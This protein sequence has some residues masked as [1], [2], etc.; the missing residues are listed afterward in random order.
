MFFVCNLRSVSQAKYRAQSSGICNDNSLPCS[1]TGLTIHL[2]FAEW[3]G[4]RH[5]LD[6][7]DWRNDT[8]SVHRAKRG[9]IQHYPLDRAKDTCPL[10]PNAFALSSSN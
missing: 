2:R 9:G 3:R 8:F 6:D 7:F 4:A 5:R 10:L 1:S